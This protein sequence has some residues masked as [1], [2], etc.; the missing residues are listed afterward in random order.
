MTTTKTRS[1][2]TTTNTTKV[3]I[4][5][6]SGTSKEKYSGLMVIKT[7]SILDVFGSKKTHQKYN[8]NKIRKTIL[9]II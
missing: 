2:K 3:T 5:K 8:P 6:V 1:T 4:T 9:T 7:T